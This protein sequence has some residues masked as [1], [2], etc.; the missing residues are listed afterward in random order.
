MKGGKLLNFFKAHQNQMKN[1][2]RQKNLY[3]NAHTTQNCIHKMKEWKE[4]KI[5]M[6]RSKLFY[7]VNWISVDFT[8]PEKRF[9][10]I[11]RLRN[12]YKFMHW[13]SIDGIQMAR[14][15]L[16]N[17]WSLFPLFYCLKF[18]FTQNSYE[19]MKNV[20]K[21]CSSFLFYFHF[22]PAFVPEWI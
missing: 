11:Q 2:N 16:E 17:F 9:L 21:R 7:F 4:M 18:H 19:H 8:I 13:S 10:L 1:K 14:F 20:S 22:F 6:N 12:S 5:W 3:T 15:V